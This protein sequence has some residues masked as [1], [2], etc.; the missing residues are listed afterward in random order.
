MDGPEKFD[1]TVGTV[2]ERPTAALRVA[3]SISYIHTYINSLLF[4][5]E[6]GRNY[7]TPPAA[8]LTYSSRLIH[9]YTS[10]VGSISARNKY[11]YGLQIVVPGMVVCVL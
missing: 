8:I 6:V 11:V 1:D 2:V 3:G 9:I 4:H 5:M 10:N 7:R